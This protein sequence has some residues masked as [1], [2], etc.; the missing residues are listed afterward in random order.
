MKAFTKRLRAA[1]AY[2][3]ND[4]RVIREINW[5]RSQGW[6]C[7]ARDGGKWIITR[8]VSLPNAVENEHEW[9]VLDSA[10]NNEA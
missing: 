10:E 8:P 9:D 4:P 1:S 5:M 3:A 6:R 2:N 7:E